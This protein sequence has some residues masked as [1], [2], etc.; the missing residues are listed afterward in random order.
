MENDFK[1]RMIHMIQK[2]QK[3]IKLIGYIVRIKNNN[4][5]EM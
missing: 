4:K 2:F 5:F 1:I 3:L